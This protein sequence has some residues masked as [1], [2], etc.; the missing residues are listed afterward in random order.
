MSHESNT[1]LYEAR[2]Q[3]LTDYGVTEND[4]ME[5]EEGEFIISSCEQKDD[6]G[7]EEVSEHRVYLP[8]NLSLAYTPDKEEMYA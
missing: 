2:E 5:S 4:V 6:E 1:L 3:F 8:H 7:M